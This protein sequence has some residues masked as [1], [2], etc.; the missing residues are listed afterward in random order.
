MRMAMRRPLRD[1]TVGAIIAG[2]LTAVAA[3]LTLYS[4]V[5][6]SDAAGLFWAALSAWLLLRYLTR[7]QMGWL[8][9]GRCRWRWPS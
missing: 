8:V 7:W 4:L 1:T 9:A 3:Q 6:M 2:L 5:A